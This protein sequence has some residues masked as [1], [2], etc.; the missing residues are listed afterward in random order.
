MLIWSLTTLSVF[1]G[2]VPLTLPPFL[3]PVPH[4]PQH[5]WVARTLSHLHGIKHYLQIR[6]V[7]GGSL[8][9]TESYANFVSLCVFYVLKPH[10]KETKYKDEKTRKRNCWDGSNTHYLSSNYGRNSFWKSSPI[11]LKLGRQHAYWPKERCLNKVSNTHT[12]KQKL[13]T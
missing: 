2:V 1:C 9:S 10:D 7:A 13:F 6:S 8:P 11:L 4:L 5:L 12:E 3:Y